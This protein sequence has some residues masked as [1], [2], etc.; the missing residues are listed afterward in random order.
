MS[1]RPYGWA[2]AQQSRCA[3]DLPP[4][5]SDEGC[6]L[7][8][9]ISIHSDIYASKNNGKQWKIGVLSL[10]QPSSL[11]AHVLNSWFGN[12]CQLMWNDLFKVLMFHCQRK[13]RVFSALFKTIPRNHT[14]RLSWYGKSPRFSFSQKSWTIVKASIFSWPVSKI[15]KNPRCIIRF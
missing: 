9:M 1:E 6:V 4:G 3:E 11:F 7:Q 15:H 2:P 14:S 5:R 10:Q 13:F 8:W 12:L